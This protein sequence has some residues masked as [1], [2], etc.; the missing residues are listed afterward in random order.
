MATWT[1]A[2]SAGSSGLRGRRT[3]RRRRRRTPRT[4]PTVSRLEPAAS[5]ESPGRSLGPTPRGADAGGD[6]VV[7]P[8]GDKSSGGGDE[9]P[10]TSQLRRLLQHLPVVANR[11]RLFGTACRGG[12]GRVHRSGRRRRSPA[13]ERGKIRDHSTEKRKALL[14]R[15]LAG[16]LPGRGE[17]GPQWPGPSSGRSP[18]TV[19]S[20]MFVA[21]V[22]PDVPVARRD[23]RGGPDRPRPGS[24]RPQCPRGSRG[25][26]SQPLPRQRSAG[27]PAGP[28]RNTS[29]PRTKETT[30]RPAFASTRAYISLTSVISIHS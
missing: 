28:R 18:L 14:W 7:E 27:R 17:S 19:P 16:E 13:V 15:T 9:R 5:A 21:V 24:P 4:R 2:R 25:G 23:R 20:A 12:R 11:A 29:P 22:G 10:R 8:R 30:G 1:A 6:R 26:T 3:S